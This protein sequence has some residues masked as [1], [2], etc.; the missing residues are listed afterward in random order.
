ML[1]DLSH[2]KLLA[3][4]TPKPT[5]YYDGVAK[6]EMRLPHNVL[7]FARQH[8]MELGIQTQIPSLHCR[9]VLIFNLEGDGSL[10]IDGRHLHFRAGK[11]ALILPYQ[12][13]AFADIFSER[14]NWLFI[15]FDFSASEALESLRNRALAT[16]PHCLGWLAELFETWR[17]HPL[18]APYLAGLILNE[19]LIM[20]EATGARRSRRPPGPEQLVIKLHKLLEAH[21]N[22]RI[23]ELGRELG[24]SEPH[25]RTEFRRR[26]QT[27]LGRYVRQFRLNRAAILLT[28][29]ELSV[30]EIASRCGFESIYSFSRSFRSALGKSPRAYRD[31]LLETPR[32]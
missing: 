29:T 25:L 18:R 17:R 31:N 13:H 27:S 1:P 2:L 14:I 22:Y 5:N 16:P 7:L 15:T 8:S 10:I 28:S 12:S 20:A 26:T 19:L 11:S 3:E 9:C 23:K 32:H 4:S 30:G 24:I 6:Q 21:P